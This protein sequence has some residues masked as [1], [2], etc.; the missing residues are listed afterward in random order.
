MGISNYLVRRMT[1]RDLDEVMAIEQQVFSLP[2]SRQSYMGELKNQFATYLVCD[3]EA[4]VAGYVGIWVVFEEAHITNIAVAP[5]WRGQ[6]LGRVLME[7]AERVARQKNALRILL[8]VRP[9]NHV[10]LS[11]YT[12]LGYVESGRRKEYY[13]DNGEDAIIMTKLLF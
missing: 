11:L 1:E 3:K 9:S 8:E 13:S 10:A 6:G 12:S 4:Q 7:E 5:Q 2:W